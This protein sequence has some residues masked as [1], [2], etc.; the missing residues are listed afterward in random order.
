MTINI[1]ARLVTPAKSIARAD[2]FAA[3][4]AMNLACLATEKIADKAATGEDVEG[5]LADL[6]MHL[7][8]VCAQLDTAMG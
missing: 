8:R 1:V 7:R 6:L 4:S 5:E 3:L 2:I